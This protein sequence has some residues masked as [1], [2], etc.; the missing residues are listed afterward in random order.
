MTRGGKREGA[1]AKPAPEGTTK[2]TYATKLEPQVVAYLRQLDNAAR[3]IE[4]RIKASKQYREW[5]K[6]S[7]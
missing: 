6:S 1:G 5:R 4:A 7:G 2:V 3:E